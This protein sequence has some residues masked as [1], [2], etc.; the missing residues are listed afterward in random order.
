MRKDSRLSFRIS[1]ELSKRVEFAISSD[2]N[3]KD[4]SEFGT[5][6]INF[7]LDY[8]KLAESEQDKILQAVLILADHIKL[9]TP[10]I[11]ELR[12]LQDVHEPSIVEHPRYE[13][14]LNFKERFL[15]EIKEEISDKLT[16]AEYDDIDSIFNEYQEKFYVEGIEHK[17]LLA[18]KAKLNLN[19]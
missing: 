17:K 15:P 9:N 1:P 13:S 12:E 14:I 10:E 8:L 4:R 18:E 7:Y 6:A 19:S 11:I 16:K 5:K 2:P 3:I